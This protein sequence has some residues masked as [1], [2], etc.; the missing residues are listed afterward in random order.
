MGISE[1]PSKVIPLLS[2]KRGCVKFLRKKPKEKMEQI[3]H[4]HVEVGGLKLHVAETGT[5]KE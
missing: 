3:Q 2:T 4:K 5:G 1:W